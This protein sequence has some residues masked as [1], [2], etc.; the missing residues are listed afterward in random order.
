[1][2]ALLKSE[3]IKVIIFIFALGVAYNQFETLKLKVETLEK[4]LDKKI[5]I[6][7]DQDERIRQLEKCK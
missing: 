3:W 7:K 5:K 6:I 1:M 2:K 4:R